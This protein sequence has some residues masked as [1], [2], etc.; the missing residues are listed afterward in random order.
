MKKSN[1]IL[2]P[3]SE[4]MR[5][6]N[7]HR[8]MRLLHDMKSHVTTVLGTLKCQGS[9]EQDPSPY[10]PHRIP[11]SIRSRGIWLKRSWSLVPLL[12][13]DQ[14][15]S[16]RSQ[17]EKEAQ[18]TRIIA[19]DKETSPVPSFDPPSAVKKRCDG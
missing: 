15:H 11:V 7:A 6:Q 8:S 13:S 14:S 1:N 2:P 16:F 12:L 4:I 3:R 9:V 18:A 5:V 10:C 19:S 17:A